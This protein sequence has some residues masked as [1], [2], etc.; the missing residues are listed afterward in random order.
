MADSRVPFFFLGLGLGTALGILFAPRSGEETREQLRERALEGRDIVRR[1][2]SEAR[3]HAGEFIERGRDAVR[4]QRDQ[5][6]EALEAGRR[7][8]LDATGHAPSGASEG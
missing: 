6:T 5:L 3:Q 1:R 7:A 2:S 4:G 8:Y